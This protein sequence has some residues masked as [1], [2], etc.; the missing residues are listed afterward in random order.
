MNGD[1]RGEEAALRAAR[2]QADAAR[3]RGVGTDPPTIGVWNVCA[4]LGSGGMG[5][6]FLAEHRETGQVAAVKVLRHGLESISA[7]RRFLHEIEILQRLEHPGIA[8]I[9]DA[10]AAQVGLATSHYYAM[11]YVAGY[12]LDRFADIRALDLTGRLEL[13]ARVCDAVAHA[14]GRGVLHR[15]LKPQNI[16]VDLQGMPRVV[17]FGVARLSEGGETTMHTEPGQMLGTVQY[18][19]P[20]QIRGQHADLDARADVYALGVVL[21]QLVYGALPFEGSKKD[22]IALLDQ[23]EA[24]L[25]AF[26]EAQSDLERQAQVLLQTSMC[27][28]REGRYG[29]AGELAVEV[30]R[31][32]R[33]E[34]LAIRA[35]PVAVTQERREGPLRRFM[36]RR[37]STT[38]EGRA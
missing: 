1:E 35:L 7:G 23:I 2:A 27:P 10:G 21:Y 31:A 15:D 38:G 33:G 22:A 24:G 30:R 16:I 34:T 14:H 17:D 3:R 4:R 12:A 9:V 29:D 11:E 6:V 18:M 36:R 20:E 19:P 26:A 13:F 25:P 8:K 28:K 32:L 37:D 5:I